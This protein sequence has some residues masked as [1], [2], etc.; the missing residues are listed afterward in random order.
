MMKPLPTDL[1]V[2]SLIYDRYYEVF[3]SYEES[4]R[5]AKMYVPIDIPDVSKDLSVDPDILFG[6]LY[7]H[8]DKKHAYQNA[9]GS[10]VRLFSPRVGGDENCVN[11][12]LLA[13]VLAELRDQSKRYITSVLIAAGSVAVSLVAIALSIVGLA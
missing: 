6:R 2:L 3:A 11:F 1:Q 13:S 9:S 8:L 7:Y 5:A 12:P 10:W 4:S